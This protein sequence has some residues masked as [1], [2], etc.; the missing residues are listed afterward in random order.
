MVTKMQPRKITPLT[1]R[2]IYD[3]LNTIT[4]QLQQ[5]QTDTIFIPIHIYLSLTIMGTFAAISFT[6]LFNDQFF[7]YLSIIGIIIVI[8]LLLFLFIQRNKQHNK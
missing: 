6:Y 7:W 8:S 4:D 2:E 3:K 5:L 1:H